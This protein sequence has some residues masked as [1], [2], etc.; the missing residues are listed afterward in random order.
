MAAIKLHIGSVG[1]KTIPMSTHPQ[2][3]VRMSVCLFVC[4]GMMQQNVSCILWREISVNMYT[5]TLGIDVS[6]LF[7]CM[8]S[9]SVQKYFNDTHCSLVPIKR[10]LNA[11]TYS[12]MV[13]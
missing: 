9:F 1:A 3:Y 13:F 6:S 11:T 8:F 7:S 2:A 5:K 12:E 4:G 10:N